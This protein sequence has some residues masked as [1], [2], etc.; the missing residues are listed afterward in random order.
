MTRPDGAVPE[1][2]NR[3]YFVRRGQ[4]DDRLVRDGNRGGLP[5]SRFVL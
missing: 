3:R 4:A 1:L 2:P 5:A